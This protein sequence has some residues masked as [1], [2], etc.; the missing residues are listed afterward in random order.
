MVMLHKL[1]L[2]LQPE[3]LAMEPLQLPR[4]VQVRGYPYVI[5]YVDKGREVD[6]DL[7]ANDLLGQ[8]C[9]GN[10]GHLRVLTTQCSVG[11]LDSVIHEIL[12]VIFNKNT[13]LTAAL[14]PEIGDEAFIS[15]LANE[16]A[17][18]L[19]DNG[20]VKMPEKVEPTVTRITGAE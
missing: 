14:R 4:A 5:D 15:A 17:F 9:P 3:K 11:I 18:L 20:W 13:V 16:L 19:V 12:H 7:A 6:R 8:C 2:K 1:K 10:P